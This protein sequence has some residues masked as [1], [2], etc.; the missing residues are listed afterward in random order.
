M[1]KIFFYSLVVAGV[2]SSCA[3]TEFVEPKADVTP[4][5]GEIIFQANADRSADTKTALDGM[6]I[7]W[8]A[9][10]PVMIFGKDDESNTKVS[11]YA[12]HETG[13]STTLD[14]TTN[15]SGKEGAFV[16]GDTPEYAL[17]PTDAD[18]A[19]IDGSVITFKLPEN[20][21]YAAGS[22]GQNAN[23]A[24][25]KITSLEGMADIK[26][27]NVCGYLKLQVS[28]AEGD[29][30]TVGKIILTTKGT[31]KLWGTFEA[32]ASL[33]A[34]VATYKA[35][36][37]D[38]SKSV[39]LTCPEGV[40]VSTDASNP[41]VFYIVVPAGA[42]ADGF[43]AEVYSKQEHLMTTLE[44]T[45]AVTIVRNQV[46]RM[47]N[48]SFNWIP[49]GYAEQAYLESNHK[50]CLDTGYGNADGFRF[51][52]KFAPLANWS[53]NYCVCGVTNSPLDFDNHYYYTAIDGDA[54]TFRF[55]YNSDAALMSGSLFSLGNDYVIDASFIKGAIKY[56]VNGETVAERTTTSDLKLTQTAGFMGD[57]HAKDASTF[58]Y[59]P[60]P[61]AKWYY[62][63][64]Y[65][66]DN[67]QI[68]QFIPAYLSTGEEGHKYGMYDVLN[69]VFYTNAY[70]GQTACD[71]N[72]GSAI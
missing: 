71:F 8:V 38:G 37:T 10:D 56:V 57:H 54:N 43:T 58:V 9:A 13:A 23:V 29:A 44:T 48:K 22:F 50:Q 64:M 51:V 53:A 15:I 27:K 12:A 33:D 31:E 39:T 4:T 69:D 41:T 40:A 65:D 19:S 6:N 46:N 1:K 67:V 26:F 2:L 35:G 11:G 55:M 66:K 68:R 5:E 62:C 20:Q 24:V 52:F 18:N 36:A 3:K 63:D 45:K 21:T 17:Y 49:A 47:P 25:G 42:L 70:T 32:D 34:P 16:T 61:S 7:N 30:A 59:N 72:G 60:G 28:V 14:W